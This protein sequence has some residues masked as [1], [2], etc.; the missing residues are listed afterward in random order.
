MHCEQRAI[1]GRSHDLVREPDAGNPHVRFDERRLETEQWRGARHRYCE[2]RRETATPTDLTPPRQSSTLLNRKIRYSPDQTGS[3]LRES[4]SFPRLH[5]RG[6][7]PRKRESISV[8]ESRNSRKDI[9]SGGPSWSSGTIFAEQW[10]D[11]GSRP[12]RGRRT[13]RRP[14][15]PHRPPPP[16]GAAGGGAPSPDGRFAEIPA[17]PR[18]AY[19]PAPAR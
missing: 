2:S 1:R 19:T 17:L 9:P 16:G 4:P 13:S 8:S 6:Q 7:A 14:P 18:G 12:V 5:P 3:R 10:N 15:R 11:R